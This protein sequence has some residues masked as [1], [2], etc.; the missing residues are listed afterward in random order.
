MINR[1]STMT[2]CA[3]DVVLG[4]FPFFFFSCQLKHDSECSSIIMQTIIVIIKMVIR[5][6][7]DEMEHTH[8]HL[9]MKTTT[10]DGCVMPSK[11]SKRK[12]FLFCLCFLA[13]KWNFANIA[14]QKKKSK[15]QFQCQTKQFF[16]LSFAS[17]FVFSSRL[18][19][20]R[21]H[22]PPLMAGRRTFPFVFFSFVLSL[23]EIALHSAHTHTHEQTPANR[24][25]FDVLFV[26][27]FSAFDLASEPVKFTANFL[28][29]SIDLLLFTRKMFR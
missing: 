7:L 3:T 24:V 1:R 19:T 23:N 13:Q 26:E 21:K 16:S 8:N 5:H 10:I 6:A 11:N 9:Q 27:N 20:S 17:L 25:V 29:N 28:M 12:Q 22:C 18:F 14:H 4:N 15:F 2:W